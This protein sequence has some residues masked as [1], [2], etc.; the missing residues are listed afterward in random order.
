MEELVI[1]DAPESA[2]SQ[3]TDGN[4]HAEG[5][6]KPQIDAPADEADRLV[7]EGLRDKTEAEEGFC[8]IH[9]DQF[10]PVARNAVEF[11]NL[12]TIQQS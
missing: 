5:D 4:Q 7:E 8:A 6:N 2:T 12:Q 9:K 3:Q 11:W 10:E 1:V